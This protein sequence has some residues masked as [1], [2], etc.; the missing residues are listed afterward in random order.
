MDASGISATPEMQAAWRRVFTTDQPGAG[1]PSTLAFQFPF[2][3]QIEEAV[4]LFPL[5]GY[6]LGEKRFNALQAAL[7]RFG[8]PPYYASTY[9]DE[10]NFLHSGSVRG[11][12]RH[13]ILQP[14][15][16]YA[17]HEAAVP[18]PLEYAMYGDAPCWGLIVS[19]THH[20]VLGGSAEF[21]AEFKSW[22]P[23]WLRDV[24]ALKYFWAGNSNRAWL[25]QVLPK[26]A[27]GLEVEPVPFPDDE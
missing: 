8:S 11:D 5:D 9:E 17:H 16:A 27:G 25:D 12:A 18:W 20:G 26:V 15:D 1:Y 24:A 14:D 7:R 23:I 2:T 22:Y 13:H 10:L 3:R 6:C 4:I 19:H 21:I